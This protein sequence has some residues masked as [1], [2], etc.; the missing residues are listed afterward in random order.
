MTGDGVNDAPALKAAHIGIA[1][2]ARGSDVAREAASLVLA[3][4]DFRAIV[5]A[6]RLGRR[7]Y[8]NL[9]KATRYV[10]AVHVPIAGMAV[11]PVAFNWPTLGQCPSTLRRRWRRIWRMATCE[12][13]EFACLQFR[14]TVRAIRGSLREADQSFS[15]SRL[16]IRSVSSNSTS[17]SK[18]SSTDIDCMGRF[19]TTSLSSTPRASS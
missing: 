9:S 11:L 14:T 15:A 7:I 19:G 13:L 17:F 2:G 4:D 3:D 6:V 18:V 1:M 5:D 8:D 10:L 16:I 12:N